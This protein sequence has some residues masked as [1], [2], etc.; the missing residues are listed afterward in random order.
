MDAAL[1][2]FRFAGY[3]KTMIIDI[4]KKTGAAKGTFYHYFPSKEAIL[5]AICTRWATE[6]ATSFMLES[7]QLTTLPKLQLFITRLFLPTQLNILFKRLWDEEQLNLYYK[8]WRNLVE[9]VFNP[10]IADIIQQG[11]QE[12]TMCVAYPQETIAFFWSTLSCIWEA[13]FFQEP[14]VAIAIKVKLAESL[15]ERVLGIK[16]GAFKITLTSYEIA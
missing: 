1:E 5:E 8:A 7:R 12:K 14:P 4:T 9:E 13:I 3:Q 2:L 10:L 16:E 11:N 6:M 15:L